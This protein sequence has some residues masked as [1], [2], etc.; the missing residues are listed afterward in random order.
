MQASRAAAGRASDAREGASGAWSARI[1]GGS[2]AADLAG[3]PVELGR[4]GRVEH[5]PAAALVDELD[6]VDDEV[7]AGLLVD[8][9]DEDVLQRDLVVGGR[10][11]IAGPP[12]RGDGD[13][14]N[15]L[16]LRARAKQ[17]DAR[18]A[19]ELAEHHR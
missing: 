2:L 11:P 9:A 19:L 6:L 8:R 3:L 1:A 4:L 7:T 18:L 5:L 14:G 10:P 15:V 16:A 12:E 17:P 13:L